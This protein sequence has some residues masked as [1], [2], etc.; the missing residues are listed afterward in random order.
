M[1]QCIDLT[2]MRFGMLTVIKRVPKTTLASDAHWLVECDCG[3]QRV[4][5]SG[6]LRNAKSRSC[7]CQLTIGLRRYAARRAAL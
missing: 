3:E 1:R 7:G 6:N 4:V 5:L 2:G